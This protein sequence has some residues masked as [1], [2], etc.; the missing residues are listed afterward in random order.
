M[1]PSPIELQRLLSSALSME[2]GSAEQLQHLERL[3]TLCPSFVPGLLLSSRAMLWGK[4]DVARPDAFF[5][6]VE[7]VLHHALEASN[8]SPEALVGMARFQSVVRDAPGEAESLYREAATKALAVLEESWAGLI[9]SLAEQ[10]K[11][12][13]AATT[14]ARARQVFP[15]SEILSEARRFAGLRD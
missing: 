4:E 2:R 5:D 1:H 3:R 11:T 15:D 12:E 10:E 7:R 13:G 9:E 14:A 6:E 8:R